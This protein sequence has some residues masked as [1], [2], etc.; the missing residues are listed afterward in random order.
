MAGAKPKKNKLPRRCSSDA[1]ISAAH[2]APKNKQMSA[3]K[4]VA[5]RIASEK[6]L[7]IRSPVDASEKNAV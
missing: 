2:D 1:G 4:F 3:R 5:L 7:G 6:L